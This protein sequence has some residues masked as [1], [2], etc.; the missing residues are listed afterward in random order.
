MSRETHTATYAESHGIQMA[1]SLEALLGKS[2]QR[3]DIV[4]IMHVLEHFS[5]PVGTLRMIREA[6]IA[7]DGI[8]LVEVPNFYVHDSYELAHLSCFTPHTLKEVVRQAGFQVEKV[9]LHGV[10]R[11]S[12]LKLYMTLIAVPAAAG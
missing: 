2:K 9:L 3:Y 8:L 11:S 4:T 6:L 1:S 10:P 12:N 7:P 5:D